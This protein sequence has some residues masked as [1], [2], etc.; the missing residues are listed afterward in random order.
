MLRDEDGVEA[1]V[2]GI[3]AGEFVVKVIA[4]YD[5]LSKKS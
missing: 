1:D 5:G 3:L 2:G 4:L